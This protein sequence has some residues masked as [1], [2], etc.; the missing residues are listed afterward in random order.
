MHV[1]D[2]VLTKAELLHAPSHDFGTGIHLFRKEIHTIQAVGRYPKINITTLA[3]YMGVTKGAVSQTVTKL[4]KKGMIKK[5]YAEGSKKEVVLELT[6][7]GRTGFRN[8]EKFHTK[9]FDIAR[10]HYGEKVDTK[11]EMFLNVMSDFKTILDEYERRKK[12]V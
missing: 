10:E 12:I 6:G 5:Q 1:L 8:H 3:R 4:I 7:L 9:M 11:I 2:E